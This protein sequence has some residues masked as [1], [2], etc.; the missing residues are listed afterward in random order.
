MELRQGDKMGQLPGPVH[1]NQVVL[2]IAQSGNEAMKSQPPACPAYSGTHHH[3]I[4]SFPSFLLL[5]LLLFLL[6]I[7]GFP[8]PIDSINSQQIMDSQ[9]IICVSI[10]I[11]SCVL[12]TTAFLFY[13]CCRGGFR[14]KFEGPEIVKM[15]FDIYLGLAE[16]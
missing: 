16:S 13:S 12:V 9:V 11:A 6:T 4:Y 15:K 3:I 1:P 10:C 7:L 5:L 8:Q 14:F 2:E